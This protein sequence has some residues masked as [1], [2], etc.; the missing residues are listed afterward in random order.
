LKPFEK[1]EKAETGNQTAWFGQEFPKPETGNSVS[2]WFKPSLSQFETK[3]PQHYHTT[4]ARKTGI[5]HE[6]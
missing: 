5:I 3:L 4:T 2:V 1:I 6:S